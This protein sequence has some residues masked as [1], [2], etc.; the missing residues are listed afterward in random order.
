MLAIVWL[1]HLSCK[2]YSWS[3]FDPSRQTWII[4]DL[5]SKTFLNRSLL[6]KSEIV[7]GQ[8]VKRAFELWREILKKLDPEFKVVGRLGSKVWARHF[9]NS[10]GKSEWC[11]RPRAPQRFI[12]SCRQMTQL[13]SHSDPEDVLSSYEKNFTSNSS[14]FLE[15]ANL[16]S[17]FY[18]HC[19]ERKTLPSFLVPSFVAQQSLI[20]LV[21]GEFIFDL[22]FEMTEADLD[23]IQ[24]IS[25][26]TEVTVMVPA[27]NSK[28]L[29]DQ[30]V[31]SYRKMGLGMAQ[32]KES[33]YREEPSN[34]SV[35][36]WRCSS[37]DSEARKATEQI[38]KWVSL[39]VSPE[40]ICVAAPDI[41]LYENTLSHDLSWNSLGLRRPQTAKAS[42]SR[43]F[44]A[45]D[46][47]L[48]IVSGKLNSCLLEDGFLS[49]SS[50]KLSQKRRDERR[51]LKPV[52]KDE[53]VPLPDLKDQ[54]KTLQGL[55]KSR[56]LTRYDF[57]KL[58][59]DIYQSL[60]IFCGKDFV[61]NNL[62]TQNQ[63][64]LGALQTLTRE[65]GD[66]KLDLDL[67]IQA[68]QEIISQVEIKYRPSSRGGIWAVDLDSIDEVPAPYLIVLGAL[69]DQKDNSRLPLSERELNF[70][71][72]LGFEFR[73]E[74]RKKLDRSLN[75][76]R[77][78]S[79][80]EIFFSCPKSDSSGR[81]Q[82]PCIT[83]IKWAI[84]AK[85]NLEEL[86]VSN[87]INWLHIQNNIFDTQVSKNVD[88][89][90]GFELGTIQ[91]LGQRVN[92]DLNGGRVIELGAQES[93]RISNRLSASR[94]EKYW[95]CPFT[96]FADSHLRLLDKSDLDIEPSPQDRG[97]WLHGCVKNILSSPLTLAEWTDELLGVVV[98]TMASN[99]RQVSSDVWPSIRSRFV[100]RLRRFINFEIQWKKE[101][102]LS[103]PLGLEVSIRGFLC[104]EEKDITVFFSSSKP[105]GQNTHFAEFQGSIDR[106][107]SALPNQSAIIDYKSGDSSA[108]NIGSWQKKGAFQLALYAM[109]LE[110]GLAETGKAN[111]VAA[112]YYSLNKFTREKGFQLNDVNT[113]GAL[114]NEG[115]RNL[116]VN[117]KGKEETF[118]KIK[119]DVHGVL[120]KIRSGQMSPKPQTLNICQTCSWRLMCRAPHLS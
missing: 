71:R 57:E 45:L 1:S 11:Q 78:G 62:E 6:E 36:L 47:R 53:Q 2:K 19:I 64:L 27:Q 7:G 44:R 102:P 26:I 90:K 87:N 84:E 12:D 105:E 111:V 56:P 80:K 85:K 9:L 112:H 88:L 82:T 48:Q 42:A 76:V 23:V 54:I 15:L 25:R 8:P 83:W 28:D 86:D 10:N 60:E 89:F 43:F 22:G 3:Q 95:N 50:Y 52:I 98:D 66:L 68:W 74:S 70:F 13:I 117:Q 75:W 61:H 81:A 100:R 73:V 92:R 108:S 91:A 40:N 113:V 104:W 110:S 14:Q 17:K 51:L 65:V 94:I 103:K 4:S 101:N 93:L 59:F 107:D 29:E 79:W 32:V 39:G 106:V 67:W 58:I 115:S 21:E 16:G 55:C 41:T 99:Q 97:I 18:N 31:F 116:F 49:V 38:I 109:A 35:K 119:F 20:G 33:V 24:E 37:E 77:S 34:G 118:D 63:L 30:G 69:D 5:K 96:F 46:S 120:E 114:P 72:D